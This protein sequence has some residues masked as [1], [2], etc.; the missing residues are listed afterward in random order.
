M[1]V[2]PRHLDHEAALLERGKNTSGCPLPK[3]RHA[4]QI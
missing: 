3:D 2:D 1:R 4:A